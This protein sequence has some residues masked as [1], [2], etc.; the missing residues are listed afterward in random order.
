[1]TWKPISETGRLQRER[2][3]HD[4]R[5]AGESREAAAPFYSVL[6]ASN[7]LFRRT[8]RELARG[9][10]VLEYGCGPGAVTPMLAREAAW[11]AAIDLSEV[12]LRSAVRQTLEPQLE[13]VSYCLMDAERLGFAAA[14]FDVVC[15]RAILHHLDLERSFAELARVLGK[16]GSAVFHEPLGHN[17]VIRLYRRWTP[18]MR[19]PDEHP[20]V[21]R[22]FELARRFFG[23]V[24][25]RCFGLFSL[26]AVPFRRMPFFNG[27]VRALD[28]VDRAAFRLPGLR[29]WAWTCVF[30]LS[31]LLPGAGRGPGVEYL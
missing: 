22:D 15:G 9:K 8:A 14:T 2:E 11:V 16:G 17:P 7:A 26:C 3:F 19:T 12:A 10:R 31:D 28:A 13:N 20:L 21:R 4:R 29:W 27:L 18:N 6:Q 1:L 23:R 5:F 24:E 30:V 25:L